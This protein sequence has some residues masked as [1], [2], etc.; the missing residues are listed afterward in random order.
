MNRDNYDMNICIYKTIIKNDN[1]Y[2]S[3]NIF[4]DKKLIRIKL[5]LIIIKIKIMISFVNFMFNS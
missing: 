1:Y 4:L 3:K 5:Q 2:N